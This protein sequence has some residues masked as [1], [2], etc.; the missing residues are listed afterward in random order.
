VLLGDRHNGKEM[1]CTWEHQI[2]P[3]RHQISVEVAVDVEKR[4][5]MPEIKRIFSL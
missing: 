3:P 2:L 5:F 1:S 4:D